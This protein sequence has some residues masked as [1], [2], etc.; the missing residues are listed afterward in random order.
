MTVYYIVHVLY[1]LLLMF[2]HLL[3]SHCIDAIKQSSI[4]TKQLEL[5]YVIAMYDGVI[6]EC[7]QQIIEPF[8]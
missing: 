8:R 3:L 6:V 2:T 4:F 5:L 7:C 1:V